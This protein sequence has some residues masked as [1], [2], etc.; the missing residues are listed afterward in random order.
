MHSPAATI[1][2]TLLKPE[3]HPAQISELCEE[4]VEWGF[5]AV[6]VP[7]IYVPLCAELLYG[8][9]VR[10]ATVVGFPFGYAT[11]RVKAFEAEQAIAQGADEVDMVMMIGTALA[12]EWSR[13]EEDVRAVVKAAEGAAVKVI[14]E[15]SALPDAT[16][17][18]AAEVS[19]A[20]GA[21]YLKT[22]TGYGAHGAT[23]ADVQLLHS[24]AR[25]R[26]QVKASGGIRDLES[27]CAMLAAGASRIGTSSGVSIMQ[28]W[29]RGH[30]GA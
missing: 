16:K 9:E 21:A 13:V 27:C 1:D 6:C 20:A 4:A 5:A 8:S 12:G 14:L 26:A 11:T 29:Q 19:L 10:L 17:R 2:H 15:C 7:P 30:H 18:Q 25:G 28:Q 24:I 22:S 3:A 23:L